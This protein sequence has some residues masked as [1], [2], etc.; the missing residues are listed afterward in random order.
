MHYKQN[1][2]TND[3]AAMFQKRMSSGEFVKLKSEGEISTEMALVHIAV[4]DF[5]I[6]TQTMK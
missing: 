1:V 3:P 5:E 2:I 4:S 6:I